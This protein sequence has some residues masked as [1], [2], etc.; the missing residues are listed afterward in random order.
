[1]C[2]LYY[3]SR[4]EYVSTVCAVHN[5]CFGMQVTSPCNILNIY[6]FELRVIDVIC[7]GNVLEF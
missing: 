3:N 6:V 7:P 5:V 1:M 4:S 2:A